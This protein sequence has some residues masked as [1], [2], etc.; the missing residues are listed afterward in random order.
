MITEALIALM[1]DGAVAAVGGEGRSGQIRQ[2]DAPI[3]GGSNS[4]GAAPILCPAYPS[5]PP[6]RPMTCYIWTRMGE[7]PDRPSWKTLR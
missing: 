1:L 5:D 7:P 6:W 2:V 4:S 3:P